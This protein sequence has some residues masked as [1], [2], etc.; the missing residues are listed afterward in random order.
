[1]SGG[2]AVLPPVPDLIPIAALQRRPMGEQRPR[3]RAPADELIDNGLPVGS[4]GSSGA[5]PQPPTPPSRTRRRRRRRKSDHRRREHQRVE[6]DDVRS[7]GKQGN[8]ASPNPEPETTP[9]VN[10]IFV[11]VRQE[12]TRIVDV[13]CE[14]YDKRNRILLTKTAHGWRA[15]PRTETLAPSLTADDENEAVSQ[16]HHH[17]HHHH[18]HHHR[19]RPKGKGKGRQKT[20]S[21]QFPEPDSEPEASWAD[22]ENVNVESL[23]PS[24]TIH[25]TRTSSVSPS[26]VNSAVS[27]YAQQS[28]KV[29]DVSPLDNLLA[30]AELEF[31]QQIQS[32][33]W[34]S[35]GGD[36]NANDVSY[37]SN[38]PNSG[39]FSNADELAET[40]S[41]VGDYNEDDEAS[42]AMNDILSRLERSLQSPEQRI[43][44]A[45]DNK[46]LPEHP[47]D[48]G[49]KEKTEEVPPLE[50]EPSDQPTDL[51]LKTKRDLECELTIDVGPTDLSTKK[52]N[53]SP[54]PPS[55]SS[56]AIQSPQPSGIP[57]VPQSPDTV[58]T[59]TARNKSVFLESLLSNAAQK[60]A[61]NAEVTITRQKEPLDLGNCRK[62]ASP[63]VTCS[64]EIINKPSD[65][66]PSKRFKPDDITLKNLLDKKDEVKSPELPKLLKLLDERSDPVTEFKQLLSEID[67]PDPI[68][69]PKHSFPNLLRNPKREI[70][71]LLREKSH[72]DV[73][74]EDILVVY[75]EKLLSALEMNSRCAEDTKPEKKAE[76]PEKPEEGIRRTA[77]VECSGKRLSPEQN[78]S[79]NDI[80]AATEAAFNQMMWF[81]YQ[82]HLANNQDLLQA[83]Y[84]SLPFVPNQYNELPTGLQMMLGNKVPPPLSPVGFPMPPMN[85]TNPLEFA[86]WQEAVMQANLLRTAKNPYENSILNQPFRGNKS[87]KKPHQSGNSRTSGKIQQQQT[88]LQGRY[89]Q[90]NVENHQN[91]QNPY[92]G[93]GGFQQGSNNISLNVPQYHPFHHKTNQVGNKHRVGHSQKQKEAQLLSG[94]N[95]QERQT[96]RQFRMPKD[97]FHQQSKQYNHHSVHQHKASASSAAGKPFALPRGLQP[98]TVQ[99]QGNYQPI[100]L[101]GAQNGNTKVKGAAKLPYGGT[102]SSPSSKG[103]E[104]MPEVG[105]TTASIEEMQDAHT[106]LWHPL[107]GS[108]KGY[109]QWGV[110]PV[111]ATGE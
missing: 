68:M 12:D 33:E 25:V 55:Q 2:A 82:N 108:N 59:T 22:S 88:L 103:H 35:C 81:P 23:L 90:T 66:P 105:S 15:I 63:T 60:M 51:S 27:E 17:H 107:F 13:K 62:S 85:F 28:D 32:G 110:P 94:L 91:Y 41:E 57:A 29:C 9:R 104:E 86:M 69:V 71:K 56:E 37:K 18:R 1:M 72:K 39:S 95:H 80:D 38:D 54:R 61:L 74:I 45:I 10:P 109:G 34:S 97:Y 5:A 19:R 78:I 53:R 48:S 36:D 58:S 96:Q 111:T 47:V 76:R 98:E 49:V 11:W 14:D 26:N 73:H 77:S 16:H 83:L 50:I 40:K 4:R 75:K 31:K 24:H 21:V 46:P 6:N 65:E 101:S 52:G 8:C 3:R 64:E 20:A 100:D 99:R 92:L 7:V 30:V 42:L 84:S 70:L 89:G 67:L 87:H 44:E 106:H 93:L 102:S 79:A 43:D